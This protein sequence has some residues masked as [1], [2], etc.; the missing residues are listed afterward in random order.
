MDDLPREDASQKVREKLGHPVIDSDAHTSE[1]DPVFL[2]FLTQVGGKAVADRYQANLRGGASHWYELSP[3]ER[4]DRRVQ[5]PPFWILPAGNTMDRATTM[6]PG[7]MRARM[8]NFGIDFSVVYPSKLHVNR[9][10]DEEIRRAGCRAI[11]LMHAEMF[12]EHA[13]RLTPAAVIPMHTPDE[14]IEELEFCV[15]ELGLKS[16]MVA[17]I[18]RRPVPIIEREAPELARY[19]LW[20]DAIGIGSPHDYDPLWQ[21][22]VDL[23]VAVTSHTSGIFGSR[24][25][26]VNF[27]YNHIGHFASSNEAF[28]KALFMG[29][30]TRRFPDLRFGFLEG[31]ANWA[32]NLYNDLIEHW[33]KRNI[34]ALNANLNPDAVDRDLMASLAGQYGGKWFE[35]WI[36]DLR[37]NGDGMGSQEATEG[38]DEFAPCEITCERD[39]YDL[40]V[41]NF[42]F[43]CEADD[44]M[45]GAAFNAKANHFGARLKSVFSSDISHWDVQDMQSVLA[46]AYEL[47]ERGILTQEDFDDMTFRNPISLHA[48]QNPDFFKG[49]AVED[50]VAAEL[51]KQ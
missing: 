16:A 5:R 43:G 45:N 38:L 27:T 46:E 10:A 31:G 7:L 32:T 14:A 17:G 47:V 37:E 1:Y 4:D 40:F 36:D 13:D 29:G 15:G 21:K 49:T 26:T 18:V 51:T 48:G 22:F 11:N 8:E 25:T 2:E 34:K 23:K 44:R 3:E 12:A 6:L 9:L 28:C 35:K 41:P 19:A 50:A 24:A 42:H 20:I 39:I 33:E 30:V